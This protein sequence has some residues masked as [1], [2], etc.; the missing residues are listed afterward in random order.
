MVLEKIDERGRRQMC[1]RLATR[2]AAIGRP[3]TAINKPSR[4]C[5]T[6]LVQGPIGI[7]RVIACGFSGQNDV[8]GMMEVVVPLRVVKH[9]VCA[10]KE[11]RLVPVVLEHEMDLAAGLL[12]LP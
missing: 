2:G 1:A 6:D 4:E 5:A 12:A 8:Q 10:I 3:L 7:V 9:G 11:A